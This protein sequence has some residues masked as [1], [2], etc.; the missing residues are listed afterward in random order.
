MIFDSHSHTE[1]SSDSEMKAV[2]AIETAKKLGIGMVF[3]EHYDYDYID[4]LNG[5]KDM[6]FRFNAK[7]YW[8]KYE[9]MRGEHLNLGVEIGLTEGS[10]APNKEFIAQVPFDEVI[11]SVHFMENYDLYGPEYYDG[12]SKEEAF[13]KYLAMMSEL[14]AKNSYIDVLGH[15]DYICRYNPYDNKELEY[16]SLSDGIDKVLKAV[17]ENEVVMEL[18]TRRLGES[19]PLKELVPTYKRYRELGGKYITL[20]SDAHNKES[21]GMNFKVAQDFAEALDLKIVTFRNR[22]MVDC[23]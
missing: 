16:T 13:S 14:V 12:K 4:C 18:N 17:I 6:D 8:A 15:I 10:I 19:L 7:D 9:S 3:T 1:F 20:G 5:N 11:G 21:I 2:E 23:K 22:K